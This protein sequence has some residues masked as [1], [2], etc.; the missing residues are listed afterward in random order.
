MEEKPFEPKKETLLSAKREDRFQRGAKRQVEMYEC[1]SGDSRANALL[2]R[3]LRALRTAG[4]VH[5]GK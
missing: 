4:W 2:L 1:I 5:L 3:P